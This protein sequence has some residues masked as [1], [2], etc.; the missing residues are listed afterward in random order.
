MLVER[1]N[2]GIRHGI[3]DAEHK[4]PADEFLHCGVEYREKML[5]LSEMR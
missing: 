1:D 4:N 5:S 3:G 2:S